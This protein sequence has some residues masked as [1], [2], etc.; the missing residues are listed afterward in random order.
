MLLEFCLGNFKSYDSISTLSMIASS[1]TEHNDRNVIEITIPSRGTF[2]EIRILKSAVIYGANAGGKSNLLDGL[3]FM[4]YFVR[5]S[6][7]N[8]QLNE[9]IATDPCRVSK[10]GEQEPSHF[11]VVFHYKRI[12]YRYGFDVTREKV[13]RE[14]LFHS[15][16]GKEAKLFVR[17]DG[18]FDIGDSFREGKGLPE[19]TRENALFLS[20][21]AQFNGPVSGDVI[22]W[23]NTLNVISGIEDKS[24]LHFTLNQLGDAQFLNQIKRFMKAVD[25]GIADIEYLSGDVRFDELDEE[26]RRSFL[27]D[28]SIRDRFKIQDEKDLENL[29]LIENKFRFLHGK[30]D[31]NDKLVGTVRF[32]LDQESQ[33]TQKLFAIAGPVIDTLKHGK[34]LCIDELDTR[35]HPLLTE[36]IL[37]LFNSKDG[38]PYNAQLLFA[39]HDVQLLRRSV[40]RRDQIWFAEKN[41][42]NVSELFSLSDYTVRKDATFHKDYLMG[43][44][45]AIPNVSESSILYGE[46]GKT[47]EG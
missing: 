26:V 40:L 11:E 43:K 41:R 3:K 17:D 8:M 13:V 6:S 47:E 2:K 27:Q 34:T 10:Y 20:V 7:K 22:T 30:Y 1:D 31:E 44:Y 38:N 21:C 23:F 24:Y 32:T 33:G 35:M 14:W 19:K 16:K 9:A 15:P 5:N 39:T 28:Q 4:H 36:Y 46:D 29:K 18:V 12:V 42:S 45:G 37:H 25:L